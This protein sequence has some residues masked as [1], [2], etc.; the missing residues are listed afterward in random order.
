MRLNAF[1]TWV[2]LIGIWEY[3]LVLYFPKSLMP[4]WFFPGTFHFSLKLVWLFSWCFL[5]K[6][7]L[8]WYVV[9]L[10]ILIASAEWYLFDN[11][12]H[13]YSWGLPL[14]FID[15]V[16]LFASFSLPSH[17]GF[18]ISC[19]WFILQLSAIIQHSVPIITV[20]FFWSLQTSAWICLSSL[21]LKWIWVST[22]NRN[23][24]HHL[25]CLLTIVPKS[26]H[27]STA[28]AWTYS[29]VQT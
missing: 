15:W 9:L 26:F 24:Y 2:A 22:T 20:R 3:S 25:L 21:T 17:S 27:F 28:W 10:W 5:G 18:A 8:T 23:H 1:K 29:T 19:T 11:R 16:T 12:D 4:S 7:G 6:V 14:V 13:L